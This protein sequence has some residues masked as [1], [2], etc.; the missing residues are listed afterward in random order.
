MVVTRNVVLAH[1][2]PAAGKPIK[3]LYR[4]EDVQR[5]FTKYIALKE[6]LI[7]LRDTSLATYVPR[8]LP[9]RLSL[10]DP[11]E[12]SL[13]ISVDLLVAYTADVIA[14]LIHDERSVRSIRR[15]VSC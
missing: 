12:K 1:R 6:D 2:P 7:Q 8:S 13:P 3:L 10:N 14:V 15:V 5:S 11:V 4:L 9:N